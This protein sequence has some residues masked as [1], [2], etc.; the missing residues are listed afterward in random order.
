[1]KP[2]TLSI[3]ILLL[4]VSTS[5]YSQNVKSSSGRFHLNNEP[6]TEVVDTVP[7]VIKLVTPNLQNGQAYKTDV[8][9]IDIIGE[10]T[11]EGK[12]RFVSI[13]KEVLMVNE[14]GVFVT[15]LNLIAGMNEVSVNA[16]D[17]SYNR[18]EKVIT[19]EYTPPVVTL[20][21]R[22]NQE[23]TYYGLLIGIDDYND[24]DLD[25][26]DNPIRDTENLYKTLM[27]Q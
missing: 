19:I 12:I 9:H 23:S 10:V 18:Q 3:L 17:D 15:K 22:I 25:D 13:N 21:D 14:T 6:V 8:D 5:L 27:R 1:M 2:S 4:G 24:K 20:A 16:M 26:L 7:P 11:D